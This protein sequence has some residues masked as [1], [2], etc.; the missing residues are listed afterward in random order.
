MRDFNETRL[1]ELR[2]PRRLSPQAPGGDVAS[3]AQGNVIARGARRW[4][5]P[6]PTRLGN[7]PLRAV[8]THY[9]VT[10]TTSE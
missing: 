9:F 4:G 7:V 1:K 3:L 8:S 10:R 5:D 2:G 6:P